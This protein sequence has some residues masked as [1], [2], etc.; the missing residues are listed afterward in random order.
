MCRPGPWPRL[1]DA[2][3]QADLLGAA[4]SWAGSTAFGRLGRRGRGQRFGM[5]GGQGLGHGHEAAGGHGR[6][7]GDEHAAGAGGLASSR[8]CRAWPRV[9]W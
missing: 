5:G 3:G 6:V 9:G 1:G 7:M 4:L 8:R 2:G